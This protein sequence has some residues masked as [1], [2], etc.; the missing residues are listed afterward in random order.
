MVMHVSMSVRYW[1]VTVMKWWAVWRNCEPCDETASRVTKLRPTS[2]RHLT[3]ADSRSSTERIFLL[4]VMHR[5]TC[6][7]RGDASHYVRRPWWDKRHR[8][9]HSTSQ[10]LTYAHSRSLT[11]INGKNIFSVSQLLVGHGVPLVGWESCDTQSWSRECI[12]ILLT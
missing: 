2:T 7:G 4:V 10:S 12:I 9:R 11:L 6:V 8:D 5:T 3:Y 1:S